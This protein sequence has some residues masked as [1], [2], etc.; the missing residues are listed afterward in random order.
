MLDSLL[1]VAPLTWT[2]LLYAMAAGAIIEME[3][4][5]MGKPAGMRTSMLICIGTYV[6]VAISSA[7]S[8]DATD[9]SRII[10]QV[11][12][13]IGFLGAGV[14]LARDGLVYGVTSAAVIWILAAIGVLIDT[15]QELAG[16]KVALL[17]VLILIGI[18][19]LEDS[20]KA[21]QKGV[22]S[23]ILPKIKKQTPVND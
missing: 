6:F 18:D 22:H 15:D 1:D 7:V 4:Q 14:M 21:L 13:G 11:V 17:T 23:K 10:G 8:N 20:F 19:L 16:V 3:H 2:G 5:I 12:T 9:P